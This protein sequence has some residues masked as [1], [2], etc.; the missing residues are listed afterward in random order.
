MMLDIIKDAEAEAQPVRSSLRVQNSANEDCC[1]QNAKN[2]EFLNPFDRD[3]SAL[4]RIPQTR[5]RS[6]V[7][8]GR[9][10]A[11]H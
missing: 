3:D 9:R 4:A 11:V 5:S 6:K 8:F 10:S 7:S 2:K 1:E